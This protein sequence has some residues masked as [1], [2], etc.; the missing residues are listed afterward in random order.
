M[1]DKQIGHRRLV[2]WQIA[3]K[4]A[5]EVYLLTNKFPKDE[6]FG[7]TSQLRRAVLSVVLNIVEGYARENRKEFKHFLRIS[8]GSLAETGYLLEFSLR[9]GYIT[10][11]QDRKIEQ[12]KEECGKVLWTLMKT[13]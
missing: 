7:I 10:E 2:A 9:L 4:L 11:S 1:S 3:D 5:W 12:L 13:Q 6:L 8:L